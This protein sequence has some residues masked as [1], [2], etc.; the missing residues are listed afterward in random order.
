[1]EKK[2]FDISQYKIPGK[3]VLSA[4]PRGTKVKLLSN[5]FNLTLQGDSKIY[6]YDV[7]FLQEV[8]P[9]NTPFK[10]GIIRSLAP[11]LE[12]KLNVYFYSGSNI[13]S[14]TDAG[15]E[16]FILVGEKGI[17]KYDIEFSRVGEI[18]TLDLKGTDPAKKRKCLAFLNLVVKSLLSSCNMFPI[19]RTGKYLISNGAKKIE[20]FP[21]EVWPGYYTSVNFFDSG[22]LLEVD[23]TSRVLRQESVYEY[24]TKKMKIEKTNVNDALKADLVGQVVLTR[25][26]NKRTYPISDVEFSQNPTTHEFEI[27]EG[28]INMET[29]FRKKYYITLQDKTQPL[30]MV[31]RKMRDGTESKIYLPPEL[32]SLTGIP[33][34]LKEDRNA[35]RQLSVYTKLT[36]EQRMK[37]VEKLLNMFNKAVTSKA[38]SAGSKSSNLLLNDWKVKIDS[39]PKEVEGRILN[40]QEI[41]LAKDKKLK[42][43]ENGQ[44]FF[45]E[46]I[47]KPLAF[48]RWILV[49]TEKDKATAES[50]V[51]TMYRA[52]QTFGINVDFP[53]YCQA[54]GIRA[55]DFIDAL[56][57]TLASKGNAQM[58]LF[59]LPPP[60][61]NEY[62]ALKKFAITHSPAIF[63]TNDQVQNSREPQEFNGSLQQAHPPNERQTQRRAL[64]NQRSQN[65]SKEDYGHR[66]RLSQGR[67]QLLPRSVLVLRSLFR[68]LPHSS[69]SCGSK[70]CQRS[71]S[72]YGNQR[73]R[74]IPK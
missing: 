41:S 48:D 36:P 53:I 44:F 14:P 63:F 29:Y 49:H 66:Y 42:V 4:S 37:E 64:E 61:A 25:Y 34:E 31:K 26:G 60:S 24:I 39:R 71:H 35:L 50:L 15:V 70:R 18:S 2:D 5:F 62:A 20:G 23:Y 30:L 59:I 55:K 32:C 43:N 33:Q 6:L 8:P 16:H 45:K 51:N 7:K 1:M 17:L 52:A 40:S 73:P 67:P 9:N 72:F 27:E 46:E 65:N 38:S 11:E 57:P 74:E 28:K 3:P 47:C 13:Y 12:K 58:V 68:P 19:G 69:Q 56:S 21:L 22:I 54:H 10:R